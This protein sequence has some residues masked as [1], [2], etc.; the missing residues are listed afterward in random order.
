MSKASES[1]LV[2]AKIVMAD[3]FSP[4]YITPAMIPPECESVEQVGRWAVGEFKK[5]MP[6]GNDQKDCL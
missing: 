2:K 1:E 6:D 3:G 5:T 4:S